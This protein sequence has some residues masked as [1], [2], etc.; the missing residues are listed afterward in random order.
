MIPTAGGIAL[1][2][3]VTPF[4]AFAFLA[5]GLRLYVR[6]VLLKNPGADD[7]LCLGAVACSLGTY[8]SNMVSV[9]VGFG[10]PLPTIM[11]ENIPVLLQTLWISPPLWGLSSALVK[12]S[13]ISSYLRIWSSKRFK[14][15][16]HSLLGV[17]ALF[18]LTLFCGGIFACVPISLSFTPPDPM[19]RDPRHCLNLPLFMFAT[20]TV[21]TALDLLIFGIPV[22]LVRRLQIARR[23]RYALLA[24]FTIGGVACV[25]SIMRLV[26]IYQLGE[27]TDPSSGGVELGLWSGVENNLAII[28]ACLP[29]L[30]PVLARVFP[31]LLSGATTATG[32]ASTP[33]WRG[34]GTGR[35]TQLPRA[36]RDE[37]GTYRMRELHSS[38]Y[39]PIKDADGD[40]EMG[41]IRV[42][43]TFRVDVE[44]VRRPAPLY[45]DKHNRSFMDI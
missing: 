31:R 18:G 14:L 24:V 20:S 30:R 45:V 39:N 43:S 33:S 35:K 17:T 34:T 22:P 41:T 37:N 19:S 8:L 3:V 36:T 13:I 9:A 7:W 5:V 28:C 15:F 27:T 6:V 21:N 32:S 11:P 1:V 16:C 10:D 26:S 40:V 4:L 23:Q 29:T 25:A 2:S 12:T 44:R 38:E 42:A